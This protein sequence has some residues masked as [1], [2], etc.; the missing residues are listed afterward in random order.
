MS[1]LVISDDWNIV[2]QLKMCIPN[3]CAQVCD[4]LMLLNDKGCTQATN[5]LSTCVPWPNGLGIFKLS[6]VMTSMFSVEIIEKITQN[7]RV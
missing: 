2:T 3:K 7:R 5:K 6:A 4:T 1:C